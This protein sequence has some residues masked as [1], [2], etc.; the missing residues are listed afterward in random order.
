MHLRAPS[1]DRGVQSFV[2]AVVFFLLLYFGM[3]ALAIAKGTAFMLSLVAAFLI[4]VFVRSRGQQ[5]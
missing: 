4:F 1:T 2:W 5:L 3:V